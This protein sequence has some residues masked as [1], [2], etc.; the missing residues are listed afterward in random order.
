MQEKKNKIKKHPYKQGCLKKKW[1]K[2]SYMCS[3]FWHKISEIELPIVSFFPAVALGN[4]LH[5]KP[6]NSI[7]GYSVNQRR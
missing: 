4:W 2:V 5:I 3:E 1:E 6:A 7:R